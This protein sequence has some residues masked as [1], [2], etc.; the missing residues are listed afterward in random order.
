MSAYQ[1]RIEEYK[2]VKLVIYNPLVH[3]EYLIF[4]FAIFNRKTFE[5]MYTYSNAELYEPIPQHR[6]CYCLVDTRHSKT[7]VFSNDGV[8]ISV[9]LD[10]GFC[11]TLRNSCIRI[12]YR[13]QCLCHLTQPK[14][15]LS[16]RFCNRKIYI[17][18]NKKVNNKN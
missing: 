11:R 13:P 5:S 18:N 12:T 1:T 16:S 4:G 10:W 6:W 9:S 7:S 3:S 14:D 8:F 15:R 17:T 2:R